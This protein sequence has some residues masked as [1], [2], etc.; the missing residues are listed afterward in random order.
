MVLA[1]ISAGYQLG[2]K[3]KLLVAQKWDQGWDRPLVDW[4]EELDVVAVD[5]TA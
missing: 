3:A 4:R 2:I 5:L 1:A